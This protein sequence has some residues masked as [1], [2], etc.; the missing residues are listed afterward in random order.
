M[1]LNITL[2]ESMPRSSVKDIIRISRSQPRETNLSSVD[3]S[4]RRT[5]RIP[6]RAYDHYLRTDHGAFPIYTVGEHKTRLPD[7]MVAKRGAFIPM[8]EREA[9]WINLESKT[10]FRIKIH[11]RGINVVSGKSEGK[12]FCQELPSTQDYVVSGSQHYV[13][14]VMS[15]D[16][17]TIMQFIAT[18]A[19]ST[20]PEA[21]STLRFE[22]TLLHQLDPGL[23]QTS[24]AKT[25]QI[26]VKWCGG[27]AM[28]FVVLE[29]TTIL[30]LKR[31]ISYKILV[32]R[33]WDLLS[34]DMVLKQHLGKYEPLEDG[35]TMKIEGIQETTTIHIHRCR[36][37]G[38]IQPTMNP[39]QQKKQE[40]MTFA[41]GG[42]IQQTIMRDY[43][44]PS[45]WD[46]QETIFFNV[47]LLNATI[48]ER[49]ITAPPPTLIT[50]QLYTT[51]GYPFL[52]I[53][54]EKSAETAYLKM[55]DEE[56]AFKAEGGK[57]DDPFALKDIDRRR[58][59]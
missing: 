28:T 18:P 22:I 12:K 45:S 9:L 24:F 3:I 21:I 13:D 37:R 25:M 35:S 10:P 50:Q 43:F 27:A 19:K 20:S 4:F 7:Q 33:G 1:V 23:V 16:G 30:E 32:Q 15:D 41:P 47:Q 54:T 58:K 26:L 29:T 46:H 17:S 40:E 6:E 34:E 51:Y 39:K 53:H 49:V 44:E 14:G 5:V 2:E 36:P 38:D 55:L 59:A 31:M 42:R 48:F 8:Y 56:A 11:F 52:E 57:H